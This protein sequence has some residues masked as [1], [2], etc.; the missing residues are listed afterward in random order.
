MGASISILIAFT[1]PS[2][3]YIKVI[4][5]LCTSYPLHTRA[6]TRTHTHARTQVRWHKKWKARKILALILF[7]LSIP[8]S[9]VSTYEAIKHLGDPACQASR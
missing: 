1:L 5:V 2:A 3:F 6:R 8:L 7:T 9:V 4:S